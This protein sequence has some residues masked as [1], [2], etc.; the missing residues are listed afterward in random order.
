[1]DLD[2]QPKGHNVARSVLSEYFQLIISDLLPASFH[3]GIEISVMSLLEVVGHDDR[4]ILLF[5]EVV[6]MGE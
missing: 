6:V 1:M 5:V 3:K 4:D 2:H